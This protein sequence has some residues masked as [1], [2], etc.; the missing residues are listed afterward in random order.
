MSGNY[1]FIWTREF[2]KL[3]NTPVIHGYLTVSAKFSLCVLNGKKSELAD[4]CLVFLR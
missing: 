1:I 2:E 4:F 3:H